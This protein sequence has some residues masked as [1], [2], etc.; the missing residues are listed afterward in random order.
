[1]IEQAQKELGI[2]RQVSLDDVWDLAPLREA[3]K[4]LGIKAK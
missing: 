3:H 4:E 2:S 1:V